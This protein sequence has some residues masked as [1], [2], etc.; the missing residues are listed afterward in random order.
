MISEF[1]RVGDMLFLMGLVDA[2][3][4]NM[5]ASTKEGIWI[6]KTGKSLFGLRSKDIVKVD[7]KKDVRW[8][9]ASSEVEIHVNIYKSIEKAH[10]IIHTHSPFSVA[11]SLKTDCIVPKDY[12]GK[13]FL[14]TV[15]VLEINDWSYA[16]EV[17]PA[18]FLESKNNIVLAKGHGVFAYNE[19][20]FKAL[21]MVSALEFS[22]KILI[23]GR[24][25]INES[26]TG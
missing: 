14:K 8:D 7:H 18:Y 9:A 13:L 21:Q 6:T 4:G 11:L 16:K 15:D 12:E 20:L 3:S 25:Y 5:S 2:S 19:N 1:K 24:Q 26:G 23:L 10:A 22:S 17:I